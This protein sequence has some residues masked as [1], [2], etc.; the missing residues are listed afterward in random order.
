MDYYHAVEM[1]ETISFVL[2]SRL[3]KAKG[4][5]EYIEAALRVKQIFP[6]TEFKLV[7]PTDPNPTGIKLTE[8]QKYIDDDVIN[9][10]GNQ[11]DVR[12]FLRDS[13]VLVL[14][15]YREG[16]PHTVLEAMSTGRAILTTDVPGCRET[17]KKEENGFLVRPYCVED[18]VENMIWMIKNPE[19]VKEMGHK[20]LLIARE[21]FEDKKV[22]HIILTTMV[23]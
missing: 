8:I 16:I 19:K 7:G 23:L 3:L 1:P 17:V 18:L 9:Y 10:Y 14:P 21:Y 6:E 15:S 4:I 20:S 12:S 13:A 22:N 11:A 5:I 2:I